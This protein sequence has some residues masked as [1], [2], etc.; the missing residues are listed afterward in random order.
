MKVRPE[1]SSG[2]PC[3]PPPAL[4]KWP[5]SGADWKLW[6]PME[7]DAIIGCFV[8]A[9][10]LALLSYLTWWSAKTIEWISRTGSRSAR[11]IM[12]ELRGERR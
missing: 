9:V 8:L 2:A 1:V 11:E 6:E 12:K 7:A 5:A 3:G 10:A 4:L